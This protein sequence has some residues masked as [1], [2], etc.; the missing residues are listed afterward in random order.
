MSGQDFSDP[1]GPATTLPETTSCQRKLMAAMAWINDKAA[2]DY[3]REIGY[4]PYDLPSIW[5]ASIADL[6][7]LLAGTGA[8]MVKSDGGSGTKFARV[9]HN[10]IEFRACDVFTTIASDGERVTL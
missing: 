6:T 7:R 9:S 3:V 2:W 4:S 1:M 5:L 8:Q 10:G